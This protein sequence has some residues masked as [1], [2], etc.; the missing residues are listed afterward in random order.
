MEIARLVKHLMEIKAEEQAD[1]AV[2][3]GSLTKKK[4]EEKDK[5]EGDQKEA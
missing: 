5:Q 1:S 3:R 4:E 2:R